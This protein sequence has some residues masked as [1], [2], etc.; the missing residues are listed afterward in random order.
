[1]FT[2]PG[3]RP[4]RVLVTDVERR[5]QQSPARVRREKIRKMANFYIGQSN[6]LDF[7]VLQ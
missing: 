2:I 3:A 7:L 5:G 1:M 4:H 6:L